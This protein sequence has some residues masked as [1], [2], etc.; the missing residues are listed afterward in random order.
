VRANA[1]T[2]MP[3][4]DVA[5]ERA[6]V[7]GIRVLSSGMRAKLK[8]VSASL[9]DEVVQKL[10]Y[11]DVPMWHNPDRER[12]EPN[13]SDPNYQREVDSVNHQRGIAA[14]DAIIM[15]GVDLLDPIPDDDEWL[16]GLRMLGIEFDPTNAFRRKFAYKKYIAVSQDDIQSIM[17]LS[18]ITPEEVE[19]AA[20]TFPGPA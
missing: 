9:V 3:A 19:R 13:P 18:G 5:Q 16:E 8:P 11:P 20:D 7:D 12:D 2:F 6:G 10:K 15:F 14:M 1:E 17:R 4:A